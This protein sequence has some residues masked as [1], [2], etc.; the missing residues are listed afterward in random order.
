MLSERTF[1]RPPC[2]S[3]WRSGL[4]S[5][6][7]FPQVIL[8]TYKQFHH[9]SKLLLETWC[10]CLC[11]GL[12]FHIGE[13]ERKCFIEEIPD[14]TMVT[15]NYK[16]YYTVMFMSVVKVQPSYI[17][18][19]LQVQLYDPRTNGFAPSRWLENI[20]ITDGGGRNYPS[21]KKVHNQSI[22]AWKLSSPIVYLSPEIGMHV[23][24]RDPDDKIILSKVFYR[25]KKFWDFEVT[26]LRFTAARENSHVLPTPLASTSS[27]CTGVNDQA[28]ML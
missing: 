28:C 2:W 9:T 10:A 16:V 19:F 21:L 13:T 14:E 18:Y 6:F 22:L 8:A 17:K 23:E 4:S 26:I 25:N 3:M 1:Q 7:P 12:Y 27:V 15:G 11:S 20:P 24:I 5:S